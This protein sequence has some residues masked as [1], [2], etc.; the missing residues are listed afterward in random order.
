MHI[1]PAIDLING[2]CVRLT[3][4]DY[5]EKTVYSNDPVEMALSFQEAGLRHLHL[6]DLD[7]AKKGEVVNWPVLEAIAKATHLTIDFSGGIKTED[8]LKRA[9]DAGAAKVTIGS[10]A[11]N[12]P[13]T[14][15]DWIVRFGAEKL[16][17]GADVLNRQIAVH[18]WQENSGV[19]I[20][21][22]IYGYTLCGIRQVMCTDVSKDGM[23][24]GPSTALYED[25]LQRFPDLHLIA[26]GG[27]SSMEDLHTL[28]KAGCT[29]A[30][31]GKAIY[32]GRVTLEELS[33]FESSKTA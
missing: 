9:L 30:I 20:L 5:N 19:D 2:Q 3:K 4:G 25:I 1:I 18:G 13:D 12:R 17:L 26:S 23:L 24:Q 31:V 33:A 10:L 21:D 29:S 11:V 8:Q 7:G 15:K 28:Q 6:V 14:F 22:F 16:I 27:V 32:E